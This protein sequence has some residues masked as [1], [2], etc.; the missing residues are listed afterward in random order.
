M[1]PKLTVA[2][3]RLRQVS[4]GKTQELLSTHQLLLIYIQ[5][6]L[7]K[8]YKKEIDALTKVK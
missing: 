3:R 5:N 8:K 2:I 4:I 6:S 1:L 7:K